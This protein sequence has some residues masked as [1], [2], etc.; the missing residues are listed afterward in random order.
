MFV[1][2]M[3]YA[4]QTEQL[5]NANVSLDGHVHAFKYFVHVESELRRDLTF[6]DDIMRQAR[7]F[8]NVSTPHRWKN[9]TFVR[10]FVH[11][12]R[13]DLAQSAT[14]K[15]WYGYPLPTADYVNRS[16]S[17]FERKFPRVQF[18][19]LS[20][21]TA[22]CIKNIV[23]VGDDGRQRKVVYSTGHSP[24]VDLA[25]AS[26]CDHAVITVGSYGLWAAWFANGITVRPRQC[27][28]CSGA[29]NASSVH[30]PEWIAIDGSC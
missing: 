26:L 3:C 18:I 27:Q 23:I 13:T 12:R 28:P 20:D 25:V 8:I 5:P 2:D 22:W 4:P 16:M 24:Y 21:D 11:V 19:V 10:V 9:V 30:K 29:C 14:R 7:G 1:E 6:N 15:D 17:Y